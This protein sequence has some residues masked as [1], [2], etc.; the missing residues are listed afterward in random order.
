MHVLL[1]GA[2][3]F[4]GRRV[5][6]RLL[7]EGFSVR[8]AIRESSDLSALREFVGADAWPKVEIVRVDLSRAVECVASAKDCEIVFH[9]AAGLSGNPS[10]LIL[11]TVVP[12]RSLMTASADVG[13]KRFVLISSLGIYGPQSLPKQ[14]VIDEQ[15]PIDSDPPRRDA[16]TYSKYLQEEEAWRISR[17][18]SLPLVVIRPG[19]IFG[20]E[21]GILSHRIGLTLGGWM[22]RMGGGQQLPFTYVENCAA[23]IVKAGFAKKIE[24]EAINIIDDNLPTGSEVLRRFRASGNRLRVIW[25]PQFAINWLAWFNEKYSAWSEE[26]IPPVLTRHRVQAMWKPFRYSNDKAKRLLD[27]TPEIDWQTACSR[28]LMAH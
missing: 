9:V 28:S 24:G 6:R 1:T 15:C 11:N 23:A 5:L 16:Y 27:W 22:L 2:T 8:C 21:R 18:R 25:I 10:S 20:D 3:G 4:L 17:E 14:S 13:V 12:T 26:Q 19:V 7:A